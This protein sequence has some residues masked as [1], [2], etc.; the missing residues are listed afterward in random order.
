M[1]L[2]SEGAEFLRQH[3]GFVPRWYLDPVNVP[4]IGVGFTWASE[5]FRE[6]WNRNRLGEPFG[7]GAVMS[8]EEADRALKF[9]VEAEYGK[10]VNIFLGRAVKQ[11]VYDGTV[12][13][14]YNLGP[15]S[16]KWKWAAA[17]KEGDLAQAATRLRST[18]VT[19]KGKPLRG[20]VSRR[21][22]EGELIQHG[23]YT[24]GEAEKEPLIDGVLV[25]GERGAPVAELQ[26]QL[27]AKGY[28]DGAID[29]RFGY[30]TEAAVLAFQRANKLEADGFAGP[31]TLAALSAPKP[32]PADPYQSPPIKLPDSTAEDRDTARKGLLG[33]LAIGVIFASSVVIAAWE[34]VT[35]LVSNI[36][37]WVF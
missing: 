23:D 8:R 18:G 34:F 24:I 28:Y 14:V 6:W 9:V 21:K 22:E 25:R 35:A 4:T 13:P 29:G 26:R 7:R 5:G 19:A 32:I 12:S 31:M 15:G 33:Y 36:I 11:H 30:G 17:V 27:K 16:L 10:A 2:S 20:L 37:N 3:E 1:N